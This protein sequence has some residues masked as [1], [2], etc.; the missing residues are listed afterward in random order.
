MRQISKLKIFYLLSLAILAVLFVLAVFK[1]FASGANYTEVGRQ[2]LLKTQDEWILQFDILNHENKDVKYTIRIL[3]SDKDYHEDFLVKNGGKF[4][5][6]HHINENTIGNGQ[7]T[8]K[9]FK[10]NA[11]QPFEQATYYLK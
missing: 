10:E 8:Y 7:V 4:T 6:I 2:S 3:F 5:Y 1:P 11:D 9:I